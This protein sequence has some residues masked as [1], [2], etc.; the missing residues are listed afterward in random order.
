MMVAPDQIT[1]IHEPDK[2]EAKKPRRKM[3]FFDRIKLLIILA[4]YLGFGVTL[5]H[6]NVPIIGW[7]EAVRD[8][9]RAKSWV[10]WVAAVEV[11]RQVHYVVSERS[12]TYHDFWSNRVF[13]GWDRW[14]TKRNPWF[15]Y[16]M[17]RL[18][19]VAFWVFVATTIFSSIWGLS[20]VDTIAQAPKHLLYNPFGSS[21][22]PWFFQILFGMFYAVIQFVA[23]FWFMSR[24]GV[25]TYMPEQIKTRFSD[26]WGQDKV[27]EKVKEN[28]VFLDK[29]DEI[30]AKGGFVPGGILLWGP[31][32]TGKTL[33]AEAIAGETSRPFVF[34]DPGSFKAM[35][36]GVGILKVR[37]LYKKL[38]KLSLKYGGVIVFF[39]EADTLGN[40]G[41]S[42]DGSFNN[43]RAAHDSCNAHAYVSDRTREM[44]AHAAFDG[45]AVTTEDHR[46]ASG[47][48]GIMMG[49]MGGMDGTLQAML[50]AMSGLKKPKGGFW[51][52]V[53]SFLSMP[54]K[55]PPKYRILHIMA[56]N[57]PE[58]L[59]PALLRPGRLD[60]KYQ[61]NYPQLD[62]RI[63]TFE[64]YFKKVRHNLTGDQIERLALISPR[65]SGAATKDIVNES[66]IAALKKGRDYITWPDVIEAR[67]FKVYGMSDGVASTRLQ[68]YEVA[69]HEACHAVAMH[70]LRTRETIDIATIEKRGATGGFVAPVPIEE[71]DFGWRYEMEDDVMT[72]LASLAG[73]RLFFDTD[74]SQGVGGD[75][76]SSTAMVTD[77]LTR[78]GM[79][80]SISAP[81]PWTDKEGPSRRNAVDERVE[82]KLQEL[83]ERVESLLTEN[84][85]FVLAIAHA[86]VSRKTITG[87]DI[88]AID[89][90]VVGP[91]VDGTW[92]HSA[93]NRQA[94]EVFHSAALEAHKMQT[95]HFNLDVPQMPALGL[96]PPPPSAVVQSAP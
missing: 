89:E 79:G 31:P 21:G 44:L 95:P 52:W 32:G 20:F 35:F 7:F 28:I 69:V 38:R 53:R 48:R 22:M 87:E 33:I 59:D 88:R 91:T 14:W 12:G 23:I 40:R 55:P 17:Q 39:D 66:L 1:Q 93:A 9:L 42:V 37:S 5:K 3:L 30:E 46:R 86:L 54:P 26:V 60:R 90:N 19:K 85:W 50:T 75:L 45:A 82:S 94:I 25:D 4:V 61:V 16:R 83:Y 13:G 49:G 62:G 70:R 34:V 72:F 43:A 51:R 10:L 77:M 56:T 67:V 11:L 18:A 29:P 65:I 24:G 15:R 27:L 92:Y 71:R 57:L 74:N 73:E 64:G 81:R 76:F 68:Q 6:A 96:P 41:G 78:W 47:L 2:D 63:K 84:R 58:A 36:V 80:P 8:Q